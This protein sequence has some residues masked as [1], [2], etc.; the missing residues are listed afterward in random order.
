M[1]DAGA[2]I[3]AKA[4]GGATPLHTAAFYGHPAAVKALLDAGA[5]ID[6]KA[7]DGGTPL[8]GAARKSHPS[9]I[10]A[11]RDAGARVIAK[12]KNGETPLDVARQGMKAT[13]GSIAPF[14]EAIEILKAHGA[15]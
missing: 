13:E 3:N 10:K 7:I 15:R 1:L 11:L 8:H 12:M 14:Q 5:D 4:E 9:V 2:N 6:A